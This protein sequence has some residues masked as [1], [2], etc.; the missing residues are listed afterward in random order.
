MAKDNETGRKLPESP[1][2]RSLKRR[3]FIPIA[4]IQDGASFLDG[5]KTLSKF[6]TEKD[7]TAQG[8]RLQVRLVPPEVALPKNYAWTEKPCHIVFAS[9][10]RPEEKLNCNEVA[11]YTLL[12]HRTNVRYT[13]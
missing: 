8:R 2:V 3:G 10:L 1:L 5:V 7:Y 13:F 9:G 12:N 6:G 11:V 4:T